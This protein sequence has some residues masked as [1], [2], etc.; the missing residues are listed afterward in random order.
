MF[1]LILV[2]KTSVPFSYLQ[3]QFPYLACLHKYFCF[4]KVHLFSKFLG[5]ES[6]QSYSRYVLESLVLSGTICTLNRTK[7]RLM[8]S[9]WNSRDQLE[10]SHTS[11]VIFFFICII[12]SL[13]R[14]HAG[15][16]LIVNKTSLDCILYK[17]SMSICRMQF[18][19]PNNYTLVPGYKGPRLFLL[20]W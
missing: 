18:Q 2:Y 20:H 6:L 3:Q 16:C 9:V 10:W 19:G 17:Y 11:F 12:T 7:Q 14:L 1:C 8:L 5:G 13:I 4:S 15:L